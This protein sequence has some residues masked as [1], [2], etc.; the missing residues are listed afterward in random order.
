[1]GIGTLCYLVLL[2]LVSRPV[3]GR[4]V[5][6]WGGLPLWV[7]SVGALAWIA[8]V[9]TWG[10]AKANYEE[11]RKVECERDGLKAE[12]DQVQEE[13]K[14]LDQHQKWIRCRRS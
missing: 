7:I 5:S 12:M 9:F 1:M 13:L 11:F 14:K 4:L 6:A 3:A 8:I 2:G 10:L